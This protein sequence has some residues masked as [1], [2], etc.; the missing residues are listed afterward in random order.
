MA[1]DAQTVAGLSRHILVIEDEAA[2]RE[3]VRIRLNRAGYRVTVASDA[4]EGLQQAVATAFDVIL[5]DLRMPGLGGDELLRALRPLGL[6]SKIVVMSAF[7]DARLQDRVR[8]LGAV[9]VL[10][11]PFSFDGLLA[12]IEQ[13]TAS[14]LQG[15]DVRGGGDAASRNAFWNALLR[16]VFAEPEP[17][18]YKKG[19]GL[20]LAVGMG[21]LALWTLFGRRI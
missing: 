12:I 2:F 17:T 16:F 9:A 15:G 5:L 20:A 4:Q 13:L 1:A 8:D 19:V 14:T 11:K 6:R 7:L 3:A 18:G 21:L 10:E